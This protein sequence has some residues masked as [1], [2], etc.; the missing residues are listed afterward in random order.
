MHIIVNFI[1]DGYDKQQLIE[2]VRAL[3]LEDNVNFL[4]G[5]DRDYVYSH[6]KDYD[7][8]VQPS[9]YEGFG[10]TVAEAMAANVPVLVSKNEGPFEIINE[11]EYG[12]YFKNEDPNSLAEKL[13][14]IINAYGEA[15]VKATNGVA[16][17]KDN[18]NVRKT[19]NIYLSNYGCLNSLDIS[20][21]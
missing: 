11:G 2:M 12:Y 8:F 10:L 17:V 6:L 3:N 19:A 7:L 18:Y 21:H 1:G 4:G 20:H 15:I 14:Y 16:F 13:L 9:R 5:K